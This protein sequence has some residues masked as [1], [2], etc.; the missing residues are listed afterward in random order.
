VYFGTHTPGGPN[1]QQGAGTEFGIFAARF[2]ARTGQLT[3]LGRVAEVER[4]TWIV[5]HPTLPVLYSVSD[6]V[7][8]EPTEAL[9]FSF[10]LDRA[11]G[12]LHEI[13]RTGSAGGG[14]THLTLDSPA[15]TLLVA[16]YRT[17]DVSALPIRADGGLEAVTSVQHDYGS[18]PSPRQTGP[19]AHAVV[20]DPWQRFVLAADLGADR[21]FIYRFD[22]ANR[23][24]TPA[25]PPYEQIPAG[26]GPR[27][28][29][30]HPNGQLLFLDSELSAEIRS[31]RWEPDT[32]R[33]HLLQTVSTVAPD[34]QG[35]KSAAELTVAHDGRFVYV[36]NR[37]EDSIVAYSVDVQSG[38]LTE[39]QRVSSQGKTPWSFALDPTGHWM[40]V[41]NEASSTVVVLEVNPTTGKL[42]GT[43][44]ELSV[45][46]PVS[47]TFWC[48]PAVRSSPGH[49]AASSLPTDCR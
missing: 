3:S 39:M 7:G 42:T 10:A 25:D 31:Y 19:H 13:N 33:L 22:A 44:Q 48:E 26:S 2:D 47:V 15:R 46:K 27:H 30:F 41:A 43:P 4:P 24:L 36:S 45:P 5:A 40:L 20:V 37:G 11:N 14:A 38:T 1:E 18:G 28:L 12:K 6:P 34:Y 8:S 29:A 16:N 17:G 21:I 9:I 32:G 49:K 35:K 23:Q